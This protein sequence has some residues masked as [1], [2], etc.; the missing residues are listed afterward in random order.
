MSNRCEGLTNGVCPDSRCDKSVKF[1]VY[2]LFL[3]PA[4]VKI[5]DADRAPVNA[6]VKENS[7]KSNKQTT[8]KPACGKTTVPVSIS[9]VASKDVLS[10]VIGTGAST[11]GASSDR[12]DKADGISIVDLDASRGASIKFGSR[13]LSNVCL[14]VIASCTDKASGLSVIKKIVWCELLAYLSH[15][16][17]NSTAS[18]LCGVILNHFSAEEVS[19]A[20]QIMVQ[21]FQTVIGVSQFLS[22]RRSSSL[23]SVREAELGDVI[24]LFQ[25]IDAD[26]SC[27][28][29]GYLFVASDLR[30]MP[31]YGPN[32]IN[33]AFVIDKQSQ[34]ESSIESISATIQQH[35]SKTSSVS[36][37]NSDVA[38]KLVDDVSKDM[39]KQLSEFNK[40]TSVRLNQLSAV[41]SQLAQNVQ[42][43]AKRTSIHSSP[44][45][46]APVSSDT[47][48]LNI[49]MFG[50]P[51]DR[52]ATVWR[53]TVD[54]A[55]NFVNGKE[56]DITDLYRVGRFVHGKIRPVIVKLR[57]MWDKRIVLLNCKKLKDFAVR[58]F[59]SADES[60][61]VRREKALVRW[62]IRAEKAGK[63]VEVR[64]GI[65]SVDGVQVFSLSEGKLVV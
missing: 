54:D 32:E 15:Y 33:M 10:D 35:M 50:V 21:E 9:Q 28:L 18:A 48:A 16:R 55:L 3:C 41:C 49:V 46:S 4:C 20:K 24:G 56:V 42:D 58:I 2:D 60:L 31:K 64:D 63:S 19:V 34:M 26:P 65:L 47:K 7:K 11:E 44:S 39:N 53:K 27:L 51:E 8:K 37:F 1:S 57:S 30:A 36:D 45:P 13:P 38:R 17:N 40:E 22:D 61:E 23:R 6:E 12:I 52:V 5:R 25:V 29:D 62:R 59:I 43:A 14:P